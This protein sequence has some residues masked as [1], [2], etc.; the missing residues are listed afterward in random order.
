VKLRAHRTYEALR[1]ALRDGMVQ[2][3]VRR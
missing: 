1:S 3:S 2:K